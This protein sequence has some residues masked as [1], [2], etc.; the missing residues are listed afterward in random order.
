MNIGISSWS[1]GWAVGINGYLPE[2]PMNLD[3][4]LEKAAELGV[5]VLQ[6][7]DNLSLESLSLS[8]LEKFASKA[9]CLGVQLEIGTS[10]VSNQHIAQYLE[11]AKTLNAKILRTLLHDKNGS[12]SIFDAER[13]ICK[14]LHLLEKYNV[15]LA[16]EN[17]DFFHSKQLRKLIDNINHPLVG[18]CLDPVNNLAKGESASEVLETLAPVTVNFHC[19]DFQIHRK[20]SLLG[21]DVVGCPVG[22]GLLDLN[23]CASILPSDISWIIEM[24]TPFQANIEATIKTEADWVKKSVE[25]LNQN[26]LQ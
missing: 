21:F 25:F 1:Y 22:E 12:P 11:I 16:I 9:S 15:T 14:S 5:P 4:L 17:H 6:I 23:R 18:A 10:G 24:W 19:K 8:E 2:T 26:T 13:E 3:C 7:A 20:P